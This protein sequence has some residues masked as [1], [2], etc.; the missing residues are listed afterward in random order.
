MLMKLKYKFNPIVPRM[1]EFRSLECLNK[2]HLY[3]LQQMTV[4]LLIKTCYFCES[5]NAKTGNPH[6]QLKYNSKYLNSANLPLTKMGFQK[7]NR[8]LV[9]MGPIREKKSG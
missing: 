9:K 4:N 1:I 5:T 6:Y 3:F 8:I 2:C 7:Q